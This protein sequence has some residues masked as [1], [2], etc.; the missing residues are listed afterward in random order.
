MIKS[1]LAV[2]C[3]DASLRLIEPA[4][5]SHFDV[6]QARDARRLLALAENHA[7]TAVI[8]DHALAT[9]GAIELLLS[10][11]SM[12]PDVRRALL[13]DHCD[14]SIIVQGIHSGIVER[15]IYKPITAFEVAAAVCPAEA[16]SPHTR[17]TIAP[18]HR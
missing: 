2:L 17:A 4:V 1:K 16:K 13:V 18:A 8:A 5:K 14:L 6:L 7:V 11:R 10:V 15:I 9:G 12:R 3:D